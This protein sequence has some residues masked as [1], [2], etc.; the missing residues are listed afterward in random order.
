MK[1]ATEAWIRAVA[2]GFAKS[3]RDA[4]SPLSAAAVSFRVRSLDGLEDALADAVVGLWARD[5]ASLNH[6]VL[7]LE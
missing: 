5:A 3:A 2:Q 1:A 7:A 4:G 6:T